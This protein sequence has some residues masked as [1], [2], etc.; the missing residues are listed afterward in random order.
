M[1]A[2]SLNVVSRKHTDRKSAKKQPK[3]DEAAR[4]A[5]AQ[6]LAEKL[7]VPKEDGKAGE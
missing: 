4:E 6:E 5:A 3:G 1:L 7:N 2:V